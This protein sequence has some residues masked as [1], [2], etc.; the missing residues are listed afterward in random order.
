MN[1]HLRKVA[2]AHGLGVELRW[3][4]KAEALG[5]PERMI[6]LLAK[7]PDLRTEEETRE[8]RQLVSEQLND[9]RALSP[10]ASYRE[11]IATTLDYRRWHEMTVL[12]RWGDASPKRLGR[13]HRFSEGEK[14]LV[15]YLPFLAAGAG[16][17][18]ALAAHAPDVPR[19][20]LLDDAMA[21][22]SEDNHADL[23]GLLVDL[24][25]DFIATSE[26]LWGTHATV[27][28][29]AITEVIRDAELGVI[30]LEHYRWDGF[31]LT[32]GPDSPGLLR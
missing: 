14:T 22:V 10:E 18:D 23:L 12:T 25:L 15:T 8:L 20:V 6:D 32:G 11:L 21:K 2:T 5:I 27:P 17:C 9:A 30:L 16:S 13:N 4:R 19:F 24:D 31:T 28:E 26:R 29:L 7:L 1:R 3:R